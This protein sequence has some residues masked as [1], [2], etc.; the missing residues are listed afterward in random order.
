MNTMLI[1]DIVI[2][3]FGIYLIYVALQMKKT[4]KVNSF[5]V[6]EEV[7]KK[8]KKQSD[9]A[10][11]LYPKMLI[12]ASVLTITGGIRIVDDVIYDIGYVAYA[13]AAIALIAFLLFFKQLT[14]GK[15]KY[16]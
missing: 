5:I 15:N 6:A 16:C 12:F 9:F 10:E 1:M 13:V 11:Y 14:D 7:L 4:K 8:C 3:I 2:T